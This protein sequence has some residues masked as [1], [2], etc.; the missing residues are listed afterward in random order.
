MKKC[1]KCKITKNK[2]EFSKNR[3][4]KDGLRYECRTCDKKRMNAYRKTKLGVVSQ[5]YNSQKLHSK[6]RNDPQPNYTLEIFTEKLFGDLLFHKHYAIWEAD[7]FNNW[8]LKPSCDRT[9]PN[10]FYTFDN[11]TVMT[12]GE[13]REKN[14]KDRKNGIDNKASKAVIQMNL[15]GNK[16]REFYSQCQASRETGVAQGSIGMCCLG[17]RYTAGKYKWKFAS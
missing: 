9:D 13:N 4:Q 1:T 15:E 11:I 17:K 14:Y 5:I 3:S 10:G 6:R 12:N 2:N 8:L 7:G 16:I